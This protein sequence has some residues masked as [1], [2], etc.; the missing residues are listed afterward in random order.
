MITMSENHPAFEIAMYTWNK[1]REGGTVT[2]LIYSIPN[3]S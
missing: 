2:D 3:A 1:L